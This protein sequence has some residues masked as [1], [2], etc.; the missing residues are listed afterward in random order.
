VRVWPFSVGSGVTVRMVFCTL[1]LG[2][3]RVSL[4]VLRRSVSSA[5]CGSLSSWPPPFRELSSTSGGSMMFMVLMDCICA[6][7][8]IVR[9]ASEARGFAQGKSQY[10]RNFHSMRCLQ[11]YVRVRLGCPPPQ[12]WN[13]ELDLRFEGSRR[14]R[15]KS[16]KYPSYTLFSWTRAVAIGTLP[17]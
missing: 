4:S 15:H 5:G 8:C 7:G 10:K 9:C 6:N 12:E 16:Q 3:V 11:L 13:L 1:A 2:R 14:R 17:F